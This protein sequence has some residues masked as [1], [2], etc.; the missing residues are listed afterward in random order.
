MER[1][2]RL[3]TTWQALLVSIAAIVGVIYQFL[4]WLMARDRKP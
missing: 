3:L 2:Q 1:L 4:K